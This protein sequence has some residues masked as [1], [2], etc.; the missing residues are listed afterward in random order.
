LLLSAVLR[1]RVAAH[2]LSIDIS[3][4]DGAQQQNL[5]HA[6]AAVE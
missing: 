4:P 3:S 6:V 1:P 5:L 2:L